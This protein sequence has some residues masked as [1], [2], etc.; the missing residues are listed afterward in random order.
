LSGDC[1][2]TL[3]AF[4]LRSTQVLERNGEV[5]FGPA[6][7]REDDTTEKLLERRL[8][9][10]AG[11]MSASLPVLTFH[12]LDD[13]ASVISCAPRVFRQ[14]VARLHARGYLT[15][16]LSQAVAYLRRG[17]RFPDRAFVLTFD[18]GFQTMYT[19]AFPVLQHYGMSA[20]VFI[21]TGVADL[22][23][24]AARLPT[25]EGRPML[26]GPE[27]REMQRGGIEFG[28]HTLTHTDLTRLPAERIRIEM[29]GSK[30][31][32]ESILGTP[33]T[34]FA[35]PFGRSDARSR[36]TAREYFSCA[37][38]DTLG[39]LSARSDPYALERVDAYYLRTTRLF[40]LMPT[41]LFPWYVFARNVPRQLRR[42]FTVANFVTRDCPLARGM[43]P[44]PRGARGG[45]R[46]SG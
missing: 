17:H 33:V 31:R 6:R 5:S 25:F 30:D 12:A 28:A 2:G 23:E 44:T 4:G 20:T 43:R 41:R 1:N 46:W 11:F 38:S 26:S 13:R 14:G 32:I 15:I 40:A 3:P 8:G 19:Q 27:M 7:K 42:A 10:A 18:D 45:R 34:S 39:L 24:S 37:C 9:E 21:T 29:A 16:P 22:R 35:Y 36:E